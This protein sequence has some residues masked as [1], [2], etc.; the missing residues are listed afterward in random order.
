VRPLRTVPS[1]N[2]KNSIESSH[3]P[4]LPGAAGKSVLAPK[5]YL[6]SITASTSDFLD[7]VND[8]S[9]RDSSVHSDAGSYESWGMWLD[10]AV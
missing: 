5:G 8:R 4:A 9:V 1:F 3:Q 10:R 6:A 2:G 7:S